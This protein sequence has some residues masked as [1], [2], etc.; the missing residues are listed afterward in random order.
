VSCPH[1]QDARRVA[2]TY[3]GFVID[4]AARW[5]FRE[6]RRG[7][8]FRGPDGQWRGDVIAPLI[9]DLGA[10]LAMRPDPAMDD[11]VVA[12]RSEH[13]DRVESEIGRTIQ[14]ARENLFPLH[15]LT[16]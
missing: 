9:R 4:S 8:S 14:V 15:G 10:A 16:A 11:E 13:R 12:L 6:R 1:E 7:P 5:A 3:G 2:S